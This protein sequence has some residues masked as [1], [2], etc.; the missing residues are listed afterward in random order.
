MATITRYQ[1]R[2]SGPLVERIGYCRKHYIEVPRVEARVRVANRVGK[3]D[4]PAQGE[5]AGDP[6][7]HPRAGGGYAGAV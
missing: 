3:A 2:I 4:L 6:G 5:R 7:Q 1:K